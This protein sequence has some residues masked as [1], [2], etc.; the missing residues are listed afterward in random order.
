M[1]NAKTWDPN[2]TPSNSA[3][4]PDPSNTHCVYLAIKIDAN[5][6]SMK[7]MRTITGDNYCSSQ[8][9]KVIDAAEG[10]VYLNENKF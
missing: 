3:S 7:Q 1:P 4:H 6:S 9:D 8:K 10:S 5:L 2:E